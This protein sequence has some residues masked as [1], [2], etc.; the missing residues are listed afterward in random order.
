MLP[1]PHSASVHGA[2]PPPN[3]GWDS[4]PGLK[5][6][7]DELSVTHA[8]ELSPEGIRLTD[9]SNLTALVIIRLIQEP[10]DSNTT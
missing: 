1:A 10:S 3:E 6:A 7:S 4:Y 5:R 8:G 2:A 9:R